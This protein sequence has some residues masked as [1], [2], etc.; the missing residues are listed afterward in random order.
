MVVSFTGYCRH[1]F[2]VS[3]RR[4]SSIMAMKGAIGVDPG[5]DGAIAL[6]GPDGYYS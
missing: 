3:G 1:D 6:H 2:V 4:G 5:L